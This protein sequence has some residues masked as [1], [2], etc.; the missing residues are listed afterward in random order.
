MADVFISY[1]RDDQAMARRVAR[2]LQAEGMDVWWD[3][4]LPAHR[5]YSEEIERNLE[6]AKAVVVIWSAPAA[7]SQ[8]VR[9]EADFAR[10]AGKIVQAQVDSTLPPIPFNQIQC[11]N[12]KSWRGGGSHAGWSKLRGSVRALITGEAAAPQR[13]GKEA[14][15][16]QRRFQ[17]A[18]GVLVIA[19][20]AALWLAPQWLRSGD[21]KRPVVA[22]LPFESLDKRDASL[23][24]GIWEDTRQA[25]SRNPQLLVLGPNTSEQ[26]AEDGKTATRA[27]DYLVEASVRSAGDRVK[28][29]A[30]LVRTEDGA[31]MWSESFDRRLDDVFQLQQQIAGEIEGRIRGRLAKRGGTL[32]QHIATTGEIYAL[33]SEARA[34]IRNRRM[35]KYDESRKQLQ[36]VVRR[37]PNFA[38]GWA[39]L[40]VAKTFFGSGNDVD[41][42]AEADA[43][44]AIALAPNLAAGHAALGLALGRK[45]PAAKAA[46]ERALELDPN[47]IEA[48][49][50]L[51]NAVSMEGDQKAAAQLRDRIL[52]IEPL[53]WPAILNKVNA[54]TNIG[55]LSAAE[56]E[57]ARL[58]KL[59]DSQ[60]AALISMHVANRKGDLST[61]VNI[62]LERYRSAPADE[63]AMLGN[64]LFSPLAQLQ[65]FDILDKISPPPSPWI[66]YIRRNDPKAIGM[67][68]AQFEPRQFWTFGELGIVGARV[69]LL[70][71]QAAGLARMYHRAADSPEEFAKL[72]GKA[73]IADVGPIAALALKRTGEQAEAR[74]LLEIALENAQEEQ[75]SPEDQ[76]VR[77]ARI[78]AVQG[79]TE[80]AIGLLSSAVRRGWIPPYLPIHVD[81]AL[82]PPLAELNKDPRFEVLRQQILDHLKKERAELGPVKLN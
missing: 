7:K 81:I 59:G 37:D 46:L 11:A 47:D 26:L 30:N 67:F 70:N 2:A 79:K 1:A 14:W 77:V 39:T 32:P 53:W 43:R 23:V 55:D 28:V 69:Y 52:E 48:M 20:L 21:G 15:W 38:P 22:V 41:S 60:S 44:R 4:D 50:W 61:A 72:V 33:Y 3:A 9:A 63:R 40:A 45:G 13:I 25:L 27:A 49:N 54:L 66:P 8:W 73:R 5:A 12:L 29:S 82:D 71:D 68:E 65:M 31:Q 56:E 6:V 34:N 64:L 76:Q 17:A 58:E 19:L 62:G 35:N 24:A 75:G 42:A 57:I 51:A 78:Y 16:K 10:N 36:E 74:R 18:A 80:E